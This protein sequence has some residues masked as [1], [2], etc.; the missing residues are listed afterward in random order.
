MAKGKWVFVECEDWEGA[1]PNS[2]YS[3]QASKIYLSLVFKVP[4]RDVRFCM[5]YNL[6]PP[7]GLRGSQVKLWIDGARRMSFRR[8]AL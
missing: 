6:L 1:K 4:D 5:R 7:D 3:F 2:F 8:V